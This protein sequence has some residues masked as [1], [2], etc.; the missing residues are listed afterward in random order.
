[1]SITIPIS[2]GSWVGAFP[3][4]DEAGSWVGAPSL[5][6]GMVGFRVAAPSVKARTGSRVG[7]PGFSGPRPS[8]ELDSG[9]PGSLPGGLRVP[10]PFALFL[11][12]RDFRTVFGSPPTVL[13]TAPSALLGSGLPGSLPGGPRAPSL[14]LSSPGLS[15]VVSQPPDT[16]T[17]GGQA[18]QQS[19]KRRH[20]GNADQRSSPLPRGERS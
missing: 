11:A 8:Q 18:W 7:A 3:F 14:F 2:R 13:G 5:K 6:A 20:H 17:L 15:G 16:A 12:G 1:M 9:W 19:R 10:S 4:I